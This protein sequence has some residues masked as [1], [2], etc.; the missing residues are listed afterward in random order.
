MVLLRRKDVVDSGYLL[1]T[2]IPILVS[3]PSKSLRTLLFTKIVSD[4][5]NSNTRA[6]N[7]KLNRVVQN[8]LFTLVTSDRS[9]PKAIWAIKLTREMWRRQLWT[10][11]KP[12]AIMK[13]ACLADNEKVVVGGVRFFL[14]SDQERE[15]DDASDEEVSVAG[16]RAPE[17]RSISASSLLIRLG[18]RIL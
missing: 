11:A 8:S 7:H 2:L 4:L 10:D 12:V 18:G 1:T 5:R 17:R 16:G 13:E 9:S 6:T 14:G 15:E 3:T